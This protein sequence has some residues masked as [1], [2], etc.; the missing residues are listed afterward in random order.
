MKFHGTEF[1]LATNADV[2]AL[3]VLL[4]EE[5]SKVLVRDLWRVDE[6]TFPLIDIA[7]GPFTPIDE[8]GHFVIYGFDRKTG[9]PGKLR[10][11][12]AVLQYQNAQFPEWGQTSDALRLYIP[13]SIPIPA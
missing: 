8:D 9:M 10:I 12:G 3:P 13:A 6:E 4:A 11:A 1:R 7:M 5:P 2:P